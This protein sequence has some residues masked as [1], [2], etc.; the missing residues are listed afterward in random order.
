MKKTRIFLVT[1]LVLLAVAGGVA[2]WLY[3]QVN[4]FSG[5]K[6]SVTEETIFTIPPGTGRV[7]LEKK[8]A[9]SGII[10]ES[11]NYDWLLQ[12]FV[13]G[14][15]AQ[16]SIRF[17]EGSK[18]ADW[19]KILSEAPYLKQTLADLPAD[20]LTEMLG[21][22]A[23]SH[24]E[25][26]FYPDTYLYT[27]GTEDTQILKRAHQQMETKL[28]AAWKTRNT[29]LPYADPYEMLIMASLIE[30]E[31]GVDG[32]RKKVASVFMNRLKLKMRLQTDP[33]VIYGMGERYQGTIYRSDLVRVTPYNT[34]QIDGMPPTPIAM[35][36]SASLDA[37]AKPDT[38]G[39][40]YFVADGK[41]GHVFT[42]NLRD[43]NRAVADYR[44]GLKK[45]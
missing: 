27:A 5:Q 15:E 39:Y 11:H 13:S 1:F 36:G 2:Y 31:T 38:T 42:T 4:A 20:K 26:R 10:P 35:P 37:A 6:I 7:A 28:A 41:G 14:K 40:L 24:L 45:Q 30:K 22:P 17:V 19:Q 44:N 32:E 3:H 29:D 23:G 9:E 34:Y 25:G 33:T 8:L 18:L 16:F 43:H 21:L 12:L